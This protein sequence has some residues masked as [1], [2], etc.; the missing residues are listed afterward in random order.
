MLAYNPRVMFTF[1]C[2]AQA[3]A[4][5]AGTPFRAHPVE[6]VLS[7]GGTLIGIGGGE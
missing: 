4:A 6:A 3:I 1:E 2:P 7:A 5:A